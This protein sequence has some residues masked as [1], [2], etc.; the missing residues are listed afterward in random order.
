MPSK[1]VQGVYPV[2][3]EEG[4]GC[5]VGDN[6]GNKFIDYTASLGAILLGHAY[7]RV[8]EAVKNRMDAGTLFILPSYQET[9]LAEELTRL[10]PCCEMVRFLKT[11]SEATSAAIRIARAYT[12]RDVVIAC[13]YHGWHDW[14]TCTTP[15][16]KG[17]PW[18]TKDFV[19][20]VNFNDIDSINAI[21]QTD[22]FRI[23][24]IILEPCVFDPPRKGYLEE[25]VKLARKN[26]IL[27]IFDEVVTGFRT[28]GFSAQKFFKITPD[29]ATFGKCM[30]NGFPIS[31]VCGR[32]DV[33]KVLEKDC[34][35]SST[36]GGDLVGITAAL[37][38][39]N[40]IKT[41]KVLD[42]IWYWGEYL[43]NGYNEIAKWMELKSWCKGYPNRTMFDFPTSE[44][45]SLFW[46]ECVLR[47]VL[48]GYANFV[49]YSHGEKEIN[50]TLD[51]VKDALKTVKS[52]WENPGKAL[53]GKPAEEVF[54]L[55]AN[56]G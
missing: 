26:K 45:K 7:P 37:E 20:K 54:R 16:D 44:H 35:V 36:F 17:I 15:K 12:Q 39:I 4:V 2:Y 5:Y 29:L 30:G 50:Y 8:N 14:Y 19:H 56:K 9:L 22:R 52:N 53:R 31:F 33:M 47:G 55:V 28:P 41:E 51:V 38:T 43:Q 18:N 27:V 1:Y 48:F 32:K 6:D 46:Q 42:H 13:G 49:T 3:L 23:A 11:G 24:A 34:F 40:I 10:I 25:I 21:L